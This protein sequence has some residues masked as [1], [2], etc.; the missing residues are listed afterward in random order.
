MVH[1]LFLLIPFLA[2]NF[3][4]TSNNGYMP[5]FSRLSAFYP[6]PTNYLSSLMMNEMSTP[7]SHLYGQLKHL[8]DKLLHAFYHAASQFSEAL[9]ANTLKGPESSFC[10][11]CRAPV[12]H[13]ATSSHVSL[14]SYSP[15]S[16][17]HLGSRDCSHAEGGISRDFSHDVLEP[18][19]SGSCWW[20][21]LQCQRRLLQSYFG[22]QVT[23]RLSQ[24]AVERETMSQAG[25]GV[26][27][28]CHLVL[29]PASW[30]ALLLCCH[31]SLLIPGAAFP[32]LCFSFLF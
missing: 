32:F 28:C 9:C 26:Q 14:L 30:R 10:F 25:T 2:Y 11:L 12:P 21:C 5:S 31:F 29:H 22:L 7:A 23:D 3:L 6:H 13:S 1:S 16:L 18:M 27:T 15:P 8:S 4:I 17:S 20:C 24:Q 19:F